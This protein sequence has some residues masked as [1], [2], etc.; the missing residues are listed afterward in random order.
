MDLSA[1][2]AEQVFFKS[3]DGTKIPM[4]LIHKKG[5]AKVRLLLPFL[6]DADRRRVG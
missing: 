1:L 6:R 3:K 2:V 4:F 5:M